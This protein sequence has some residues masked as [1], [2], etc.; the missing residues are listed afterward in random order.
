[1][2]LAILTSIVCVLFALLVAAANSG[3]FASGFGATV[4][5]VV[6]AVLLAIY[7]TALVFALW[8][9]FEGP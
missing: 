7:G 4:R 1:M 5:I 3:E 8:R 6:L 9:L 2:K